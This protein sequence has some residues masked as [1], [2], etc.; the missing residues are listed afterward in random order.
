[1]LKDN[2]VFIGVGQCGGNLVR[3]LEIK[4]GYSCFYINTSTEDLETID[5]DYDKLYH[6]SE[7]KG[8]AKDRGLA[9][10]S[11][12]KDCKDELIA[13]KI[14]KRY[15]NATVYTFAF[16]TGGGTG[17]GMTTS[18]IKRMKEFYPDKIINA[19]A[20]KPHNSE[21]M[22]IQYNAMEC[23]VELK[24]LIADKVLNNLQIIDNNKRDYKDKSAINLEYSGLIDGIMSFNEITENGN[25]DEQE[26][27]KLYTTEGVSII[28]EFGVNDFGND[29]SEAEIN[30]IFAKYNKLSETHG[31]ILNKDCDTEI[32]RAL[33]RDTFGYP[34][35]TMATTWEYETNVVYVAGTEFNNAIILELKESY[36][37]IK[38]KRD[39]MVKKEVENVVIDIDFS[40]VSQ[41]KAQSETQTKRPDRRRKVGIKGEM[42][43]Y[44]K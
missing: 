38:R 12:M 8:M 4:G 41:I 16:S 42:S 7:T 23:F 14:Y 34:L 1:M 27:E 39:E 15:A 35:G 25:L 13:E 9:K 22:L 36:N 29:M 10:D 3:Q 32:N 37:N 6:I 2:C 24:H 26:L 31:V 17:G 11:I 20:V 33:I 21:D 40:E 18:I 28:C 30:T 5:T 19:I 43:R 44:R